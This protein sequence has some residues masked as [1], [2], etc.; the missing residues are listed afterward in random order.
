MP[1]T[2]RARGAG[3]RA[4]MSGVIGAV[5]ATVLPTVVARWSWR[6]SACSTIRST[7]S[8]TRSSAARCV[9]DSVEVVDAVG[10]VAVV[11]RLRSRFSRR[12]VLRSIL[13]W[14]RSRTSSRRSESN[15]SIEPMTGLL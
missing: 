1:L 7:W 5:G 13:A 4:A 15:F 9:A 14:R 10:I 3:L 6:S 2:G 11:V 12:S 8:R